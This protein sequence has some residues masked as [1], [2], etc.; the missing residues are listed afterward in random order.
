[1]L[2]PILLIL[3]LLPAMGGYSQQQHLKKRGVIKLVDTAAQQGWILDWDVK[4]YEVP[5]TVTF[6]KDSSATEGV[7]FLPAEIDYVEVF[8][9]DRYEGSNFSFTCPV[10][11]RLR[12]DS[13]SGEGLRY[14]FDKVLVSGTFTL[15]EIPEQN[16]SEYFVRFR[17]KGA[18]YLTYMDFRPDPPP[19]PAVLRYYKDNLCFIVRD[20]PFSEAWRKYLLGKIANM[21]P[22]SL[23]SLI[24]D[25][26]LADA[27]TKKE[28]HQAAA[29]P[30]ELLRVYLSVGASQGY[31]RLRD[32][33]SGYSMA[34]GGVTSLFAA[35]ELI[36]NVADNIDGRLRFNFGR[37][38]HY[39]NGF[40]FYSQE[41]G[42]SLSFAWPRKKCGYMYLGV[43]ANFYKSVW[44][45]KTAERIINDGFYLDF[46]R[47]WLCIYWRWGIIARKWNTEIGLMGNLFSNMTNGWNSNPTGIHLYVA[48]HFNFPVG[49]WL[50]GHHKNKPY[51]FGH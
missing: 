14:S 18:A 51:L 15:L 25:F 37:A 11:G 16:H 50:T 39:Y 4:K 41:S 32:P 10:S 30:D 3:L 17:L 28:Q 44:S 8:G 26:N 22:S 38:H 2:K 43:G 34:R 23:A 46:Q 27:E 49:K 9:G 35:G 42:G 21:D 29:N 31:S 12:F 5:A 47:K 7:E 40:Y 6:F 36:V 13:E 33:K 45:G 20:F 1:M 48:K 19:S 24:S